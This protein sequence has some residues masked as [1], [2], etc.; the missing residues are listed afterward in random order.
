[1]SL[2]Q[3]STTGSRTFYQQRNAC[4]GCQAPLSH[5]KPVM[6]SH[7]PAES[8]TLEAHSHFVSGY[9]AAR[10]F[11]T[12]YRCGDC[13]VFYCPLYY[14]Q[15]QL[16]RL[17][18]RQAENMAEAPLA[19]RLRTQESYAKLLM[20]HSRMT[21]DFLELG[22]DIGLFTETCARA[23]AFDHFWLYEPNREVHDQ[24]AHR[25][26]HYQYTIRDSHFTSADVP[27]GS[28]STAIMIHVLDHL[29]D[30]RQTLG[31]IHQSLEPGGILFVVMHNTRSMLTRLLGRRW[32]PFALQHPHLFSPQSLRGLFARTG[33]ET[34]EIA[35]SENYFP[36]AYLLRAGLS[37]LG[38][39]SSAALN[40]QWPMVRLPLGN[41]V[42]IARKRAQ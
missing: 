29:L 15:A 14:T 25:L 21:G 42:A 8:L 18:G 34:I 16:D 26:R 37:V 24:L 7:P 38:L 1:M 3:N 23:G 41:I 40:W 36:A 35:K 13:S 2:T 22:S 30:P 9:T 33:F 10:I 27:T 19:A 5:A 11:F 32:P 6:A 39:R 4:P 17:Y 28:I 31:E 12:Y 20:R